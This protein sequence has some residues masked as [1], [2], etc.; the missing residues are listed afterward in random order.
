MGYELALKHI[1]MRIN[2]MLH[3]QKNCK[4]YVLEGVA[5][6]TNFEHHVTVIITARARHFDQLRIYYGISSYEL[7]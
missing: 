3:L 5:D 4:V 6:G 7:L 2:L 1:S